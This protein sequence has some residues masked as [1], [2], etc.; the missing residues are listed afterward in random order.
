MPGVDFVDSPGE[1]AGALVS[2]K[3]AV[4]IAGWG[5]V[6][7]LAIVSLVVISNT[8][9]LTVFARRKEINIM[10]FVGATNSFIRLPFLVEGTA[11]GIF[12]ALLSFG[13]VSGAY[14]G[15]IEAL[16]T[17]GTGWLSNL[18]FNLLSYQAVWPWLA[19]GFLI[20]GV[21]IGGFGSAISIRKHLK[22]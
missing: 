15:V 4:N 3:Q 20:S 2:L 5:L 9:R 18:Y 17:Q 21:V 16:S 6:A 22:V 1:L 7:V 8:I 14:L 12:S 10:K 13:I 11:I 19:G